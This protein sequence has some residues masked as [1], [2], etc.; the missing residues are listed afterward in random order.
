[1]ARQPSQFYIGES[2]RRRSD[3]GY[4]PGPFP[5]SS[6]TTAEKPGEETAAC[7]PVGQE[8]INMMKAMLEMNRE[9]LTYREECR[10]P[11][12]SL[13][14]KAGRWRARHVR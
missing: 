5:T 9:A 13:G 4:G 2:Q 6:P 12:L 10:G 8:F 3:G 14:A 7:M 11:S 1:M